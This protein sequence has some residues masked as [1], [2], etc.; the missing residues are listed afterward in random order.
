MTKFSIIIVAK[1]AGAKI[2]HLLQSVKNLSD[3]I[4]VCDTGS[5]DNTINIALASGAKVYSIPWKGYGRSKNIAIQFATYNWILSLD[6]DEKLDAQLYESLKTWQP[7]DDTAVYQVKWKNFLGNK[8][9]R[10]SDWGND[11][12]TRL[13]NKHVVRWNNAIA[14][15]NVISNVA[16]RKEKLKGFLEHYTFNDEEDYLNKMINSA[17]LTALQYH[18]KEKKTNFLHIRISALYDFI[19]TYFL[20]SGFRDGQNGWLIA[21]TKAFYTYTKYKKLKEL[22]SN[23]ITT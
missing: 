11:W 20:K 12:K 16:L 4:V 8:W 22:N 3:D 17:N 1:D 19:K 9:I 15:E 21:K 23:K 18:Q 2:G 5:T 6:S 13:F 10:H 14:H 7:K